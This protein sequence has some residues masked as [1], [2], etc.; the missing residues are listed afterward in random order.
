M[1]TLKEDACVLRLKSVSKFTNRSIA[2]HIQYGS[3]EELFFVFLIPFLR[4]LE[5]SELDS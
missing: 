2:L 1:K 3:R 4:H 5:R